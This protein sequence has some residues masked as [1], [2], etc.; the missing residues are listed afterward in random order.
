MP[1]LD[2]TPSEAALSANYEANLPGDPLNQRKSPLHLAAEHGHLKKILSL[3]EQGE[4]V[5]ST[6][7]L[8]KTALHNAAGKGF[9]EVVVALIESGA[10]VHAEDQKGWTSLHWA[11]DW[12]DKGSV[13]ALVAA[14]ANINAKDIQGKSALHIL[15][16]YNDYGIALTLL[17]AGADVNAKDRRGWTPLD[18]VSNSYHKNMAL[19]LIAYGAD[20]SPHWLVKDRGGL[21]DLTMRQAATQG[22]MLE[23]LRELLGTCPSSAPMDQPETLVKLA[24]QH[25]Q[26]STSAF[27]QSHIAFLA[28]DGVLATKSRSSARVKA[29]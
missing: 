11:A 7:Y 5:D 8:G 24:N 4:D 23:R 12:A 22:G 18:V 19:T 28:I 3:I 27:L 14:G 26:T 15:S 17:D 9:T 10:D 25:G 21:S 6:D 20:I 29:I 2:N 13:T 1:N 16:T